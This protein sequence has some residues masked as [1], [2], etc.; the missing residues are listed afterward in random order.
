VIV[1]ALVFAWKHA[2]VIHAV[3]HVD[4]DGTKV[5]SLRGPLF[6]GSCKGFLE[7]FAPK[8]DPDDVVV[9]FVLARV[10]DRSAIEAIDTLA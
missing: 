4:K 7:L 8:S 3:C 10:S 9:E 2:K 1:S 5:Y 6:F